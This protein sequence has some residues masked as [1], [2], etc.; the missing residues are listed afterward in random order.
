M[1]GLGN[2]M[3]DKANYALSSAETC[4][5]DTMNTFN[6][7]LSRP[8]ATN[9]TSM[10]AIRPALDLSNIQYGKSAIS[11]MLNGHAISVNGMRTSLTADLADTL[12]GVDFSSD[13]IV[14]AIYELRSDVQ[15]LS[16]NMENI[17]MVMDTGAVVGQ[18]AKPMDKAL[19]RIS[20]QRV[21][22]N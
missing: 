14:D 8:F 12:S 7:I 6:D 22:R 3:E 4:A 13:D 15:T 2:G 18:L 5:K 21:R 1:E 20:V 19:G 16:E 11:S 10:N 9:Y 17:Q